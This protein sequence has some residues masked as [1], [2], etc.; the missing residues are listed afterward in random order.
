MT[1]LLQIDPTAILSQISW[2]SYLLIV[3]LGFL[4]IESYYAFKET[5]NGSLWKRYSDFEKIIIVTLIGFA[6][7]LFVTFLIIPAMGILLNADPF[8]HLLY[9]YG[10]LYE[11]V[12]GNL[13]VLQGSNFEHF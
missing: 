8:G 9:S 11:K 3:L 6:I 4:I 5:Y 12:S 10:S 7:Y 13:A 1:I 2:L